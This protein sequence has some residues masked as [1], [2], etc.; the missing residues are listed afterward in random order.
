MI[1]DVQSGY[2]FFIKH[3]KGELPDKGS[4]KRMETVRRAQMKVKENFITKFKESFTTKFHS[5]TKRFGEKFAE[6]TADGV[7]VIEIVL[8][9]VILIGL[10]LIF[11]DQIGK[12]INN[13]FSS[14][15]SDA[16]GI[17]TDITV[18]P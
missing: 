12:I 16:I 9:L 15:N 14:I 6:K 13:A 2:Y 10:I 4:N 17:A 5:L 7:G 18:S 3:K 1:Y 11:K 8:I